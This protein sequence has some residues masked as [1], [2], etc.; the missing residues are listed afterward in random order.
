MIFSMK[1]ELSVKSSLLNTFQIQ[2][3]FV[4]FLIMEHK[5]LKKDLFFKRPL[6]TFP[7][8]LE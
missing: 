4:L 5:S 8:R 1:T 2:A 6:K 7:Q 3:K